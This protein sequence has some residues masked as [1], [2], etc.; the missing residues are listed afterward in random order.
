MWFKFYCSL[1][2]T[3]YICI[4]KILLEGREEIVKFLELG[5][6][7]FNS[8][9]S[10]QPKHMSKCIFY[11]SWL[12]WKRIGFQTTVILSKKQVNHGT[13]YNLASSFFVTLYLEQHPDL[14]VYLKAE[15]LHMPLRTPPVSWSEGRF[16]DQKFYSLPLEIVLNWVRMWF[17]II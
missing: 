13:I 15:W 2:N 5:K 4:K 17:R 7:F 10:S 1:N 9:L 3:F 16:C 14:N 12:I 8:C 11:L 6:K